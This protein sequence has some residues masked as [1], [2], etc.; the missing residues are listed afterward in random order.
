M[1]RHRNTVRP[2]RTSDTADLSLKN[3]QQCP[4]SDVHVFDK[5]Q[6]HTAQKVP[7]WHKAHRR[8]IA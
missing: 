6:P 2:P 3:A 7:Q 8:R 1:R 4:K 5:K